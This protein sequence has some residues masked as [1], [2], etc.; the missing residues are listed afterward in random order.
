M[1]LNVNNLIWIDL[2]MTGLN[3]DRDRILEIAILLTDS[4][5]NILSEGLLFTICQ[6][7]LQLETMDEWNIQTHT[8]S[9][10]INRVKVS[11]TS[12][13]DAEVAILDFLKLWVPARS[14]PMCGNSIAQD[15]RF[16]FKY[17]PDL[18]SYF[19]YRYIDVST[20]KELVRRWKPEILLGLHKKGIHKALEDV[21]DS[22]SE[23]LYYRK[24]FI[25]CSHP[26]KM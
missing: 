3:P 12:E 4:D 23:L 15:R 19:H 16:L 20:I 18:E 14:S 5:L 25:Q 8:H 7:T 26:S 10:L 11:Q 17:M 13:R 9:G 24:H 21:H 22:I 6:P 2:E 1:T